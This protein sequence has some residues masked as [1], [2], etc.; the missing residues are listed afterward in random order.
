MKDN[1]QVKLR[2]ISQNIVLILCY[3]QLMFQ[4]DLKFKEMFDFGN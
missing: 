3:L 1:Y 2:D 4:Y